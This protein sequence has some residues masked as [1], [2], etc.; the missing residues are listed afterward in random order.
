MYHL[1][2]MPIDTV[3]NHRGPKYF[4]FKGHSGIIARWGMVDYG[5]EPVALVAANVDDPTHDTLSG[6]SDVIALPDNLDATLTG[7]VPT[8]Q[9]AL[10]G[11]NIPA[12][13]VN[14]SFTLRLFLRRLIGVFFLLQRLNGLIGNIPI[15]T[16]QPRDLNTQFGVLPM[17]VQGG[18]M[19]AMSEVGYVNIPDTTSL[20]QL[21]NDFGVFHEGTPKRIAEL[22]I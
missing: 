5:Y 14:A 21:I 7:I 12:N 10:E 3:N 1:Y 19:V 22:V 9:T 2:I 11:L 4:E 8:L 17:A 18:L 13:W 16:G 6:Y 20:R 15:F